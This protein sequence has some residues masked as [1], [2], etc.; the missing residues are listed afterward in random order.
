M[1]LFKQETINKIVAQKTQ[2][3]VEIV[4]KVIDSFYKSLRLTFTEGKVT[5]IILYK[6]L[7]FYNLENKI[8]EQKNN[9]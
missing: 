1:L 7:K 5:T 8:N 6:F 9:E 2:I 4:D 3:P